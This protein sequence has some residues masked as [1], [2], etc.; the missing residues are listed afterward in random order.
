MIIE[1]QYIEKAIFCLADTNNNKK[2][3]TWIGKDGKVRSMSWGGNQYTGG[4]NKF[5]K[6]TSQRLKVGGK[7]FGF[8]SQ[9]IT[10]ANIEMDY[11]SGNLTQFGRILEHGINIGSS[12]PLYGT[13]FSVFYELG[14]EHGP[15]TWF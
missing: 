3:G 11:R 7:L 6:V 10:A 14:K 1:I 13:V 12:I 9:I 2:N 15:S 4:K 8:S 5:A